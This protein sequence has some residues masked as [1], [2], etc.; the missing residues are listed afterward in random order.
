MN[1]FLDIDLIDTKTIKDLLDIGHKLKAQSE[2][3][4]FDGEILAM[5]FEKPSTRT[6]ISFEIGIKQLNGDAVILDQNDTQLGRGE[7]IQDTIKVIS[8]YANIIMYRGT[9]EKR[10]ESI[11]DAS[12]V[13]IINGLTDKSHPCQIMADLMTLQEKYKNID[14]LTITWIGDGNNVCNSWIHSC[15]HFN[16]EFRI[17]APDRYLPNLLE[18]EKIKNLGREIKLF[19]EPRLAVRDSDVVITDTWV[20]MG[21]EDESKRIKEFEGFQVNKELMSC[22]KERA[23]FLHCL[24]AHRGYE[25]SSEVIDGENSLVWEEAHNRLHIQKAIL[26][27]CLRKKI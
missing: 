21:M 25:V 23:S 10:L 8:K 11:V 5:I 1:H 19:N 27:W 20:S 17:C 24:P 22:A 18:I 16:F 13:P 2:T 12:A 7:S 3:K 14:D 15:K 4:Y 9:S 6:R 26:L